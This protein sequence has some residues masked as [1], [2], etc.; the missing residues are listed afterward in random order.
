MFKDTI[1]KKR[2]AFS[3]LSFVFFILVSISTLAQEKKPKVALVL[4]GSGAKGVAH[5]PLL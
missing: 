5:I 1:S 4:S 3:F 2:H